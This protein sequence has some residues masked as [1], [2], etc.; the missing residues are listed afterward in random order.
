MYIFKKCSKSAK[1][2][3]KC[4]LKENISKATMWPIFLLLLNFISSRPTFRHLIEHI[5][6]AEILALGCKHTYVV[7][8]NSL[9]S[10][11]GNT[12]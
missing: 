6:S 12:W 3:T 11:C 7:W 5:Y 1:I 10:L 2:T 9:V 8:W 4:T